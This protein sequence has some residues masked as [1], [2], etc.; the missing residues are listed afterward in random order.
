[1]FIA[2]KPDFHDAYYGRSFCR[3]LLGNF[4]EGWEDNEHRWHSQ[5]YRGEHNPAYA[6]LSVTRDS[7]KNTRVLVVAEQGVGD[8]IMFAS[9]IP[10][11]V[12]DA[13]S[14]ALECD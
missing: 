13:Q 10:D 7:L 4:A 8:E 3:L 9:M 1:M 14:V 5:S 12:Q 6:A 11:L 2:L